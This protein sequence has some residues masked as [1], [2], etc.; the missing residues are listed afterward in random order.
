[1]GRSDREILIFGN[2][3]AYFNDRLEIHWK[4]S[5]VFILSSYRNNVVKGK[6]LY[7]FV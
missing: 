7:Q 2:G 5:I 3:I 4:S 1:M 6:K